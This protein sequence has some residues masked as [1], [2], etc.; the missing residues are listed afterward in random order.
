MIENIESEAINSII[1][2]IP[3]DKFPAHVFI[4]PDGNGRWAKKFNMY[5]SY[6]HLHG[7][8]ILREVLDSLERLP[9]KFVT[10]W[11]FASDN[12]KRP[13]KEI[14]FLMEIFEIELNA[15]FPKLMQNDIRFMHL[16]RKDRI[17]E[18]LKETINM[19]EDKT[20]QNTHQ[21]LSFAIDFGGEDQM[22]RMLA[23]A[24]ALP[25]DIKITPEIARRLRD[26]KG[27]VPP[28]DLIIRTSGERRVNDIGWLGIDA[29]FY[30]ISK[31]LPD[32]R[33]EDFMLAILDYSKRDR[34]FGGRPN[35]QQ[36]L[37]E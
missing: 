37:I 32:S 15:S 8:E 1:E 3:E 9:I 12:W 35:A 7:T 33:V 24:R 29:E 21:V 19:I 14:S 20:K 34:R 23:A 26:G 11:G 25:V 18:S 2:K 31:L 4:I 5:P 6:G 17:P 27:E 36:I 16:G 10:V 30:S 13:A 28:A 22:F